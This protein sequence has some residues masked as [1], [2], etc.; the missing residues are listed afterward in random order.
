MKQYFLIAFL[1]FLI[2]LPLILR[3][4]FI[5]AD[6]Y[7]YLNVICGKQTWQNT[8]PIEKSIFDSLDCKLN[9]LKV[10]WL[11][12]IIFDLFLIYKFAK[13]N[14]IDVPFDWLLLI[15][16]GFVAGNLFFWQFENDQLAFPLLLLGLIYGLQTEK[17]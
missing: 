5:G 14:F 12:L 1:L 16:F 8:L 7:Y 10:F 11:F 4:N 9:V 17:Y 13:C 6:S 3:Q 2:F 15:G